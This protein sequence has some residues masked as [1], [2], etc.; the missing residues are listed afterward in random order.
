MKTAKIQG[1]N[2][3]QFNL[4]SNKRFLIHQGG[5]R[6]SKT[7]SIIQYLVILALKDSGKVYTI[8]RKTLPALKATALRD[9]IEVLRQLDIYNDEHF[10]KSELIY[11]LNGNTIEFISV[12]QPAKI[13]GRKREILFLNECNELQVEDFRQLE[14]RT[15]EKIIMDFNP[16]DS[17][18]WHYDLIESKPDEVDFMISTYL[19][20]PFLENSI[21]RS[22]EGYKDT[23]DL[24]WKI[25]GLGQK[26][27]AKANIYTNYKTYSEH[28]GNEISFGLDFGWNHPT[29][30]VKTTFEDGELYVEELIY[31]SHIT[32][33]ELID[34][35]SLVISNRNDCIWAD[36]ANPEGI[37]NIKRAGY[38]IKA[39][40]KSVK[41]GIDCVKTHKLFVKAD[42]RNLLRELQ[43]YR[44][45][46][47][48]G[49][50]LDEPVKAHDDGC[51]SMRY[52]IFNHIKSTRTSRWDTTFEF[53]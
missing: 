48:N 12:D 20:N 7:W 19:D 44:W 43:L 42:S 4:N 37:E 39:A 13:R 47:V 38:N 33:Q 18:G 17:I 53:I 49:H 3:L 2:L 50:I 29:V 21:K 15:T 8:C 30:L 28:I 25:F 32:N 9:F 5:S 1:S 16:S 45:K 31:E 6:S 23:D 51:D 46:E 10:N 36:A 27:I 24:F 41:P 11:T 26:G 35:L 14:M 40:D 52:G 22:I 34:K